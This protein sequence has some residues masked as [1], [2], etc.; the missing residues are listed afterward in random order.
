MLSA[1]LAVLCIALSLGTLA[2]LVRIAYS[3]RRFH[4]YAAAKAA[5]SAAFLITAAAGFALC[6]T[7][8]AGGG[9]LA[10]GLALCFAGDVLLGLANVH[11]DYFG[12]FFAA[13]AAAFCAAHL[14]FCTLF[15]WLQPLSPLHMVLPAVLVMVLVPC[16][17]DTRRFR[18]RRMKYPALVYTFCVGLMCALSVSLGLRHPGPAGA[19]AAVGGVLFLVSD[20]TL[21]FLYFYH[22]KRALLRAAN[23]ISYYLGMLCL[24]FLAWTGLPR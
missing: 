13:G 18:L 5:A 11:A 4:L 12:H 22:K 3:R 9:L 10:A 16:A 2:F 14:V 17:R 20:A 19:L 8:D 15:A 7:L 24:A 23:L 1:F 21:L 6:G